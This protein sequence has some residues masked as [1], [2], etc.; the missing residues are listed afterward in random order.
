MTAKRNCYKSKV[1][2]FT[3]IELL[4]VVAV[5]AILAA[6]GIPAY[7]GYQTSSRAQAA[8]AQYNQVHAFLSGEAKRCSSSRVIQLLDGNGTQTFVGGL[9]GVTGGNYACRTIGAN[10]LNAAAIATHFSDPAIDM[11]NVYVTGTNVVTANA[12]APTTL[13]T[14]NVTLAANGTIQGATDITLTAC[15]DGYFRAGGAGA[16]APDGQCQ[17]ANETVTTVV[18]IE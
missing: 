12:A 8:E 14:V 1:R 4:V 18:T 5:I 17:S 7:N 9:S 11:Q 3:L 10:N 13:G 16:G 2:G 15:L 6:V